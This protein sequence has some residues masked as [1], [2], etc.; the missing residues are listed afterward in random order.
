MKNKAVEA[1]ERL[2]LRIA[3]AATV[4]PQRLQ[5]AAVHPTLAAAAIMPPGGGRS[6]EAWALVPDD[7]K[8]MLKDLPDE[9]IDL[10]LSKLVQASTISYRELTEQ[11]VATIKVP[12]RGL[13]RCPSG[14]RDV[15]SD[16]C[17]A[18]LPQ[19][20][21]NTSGQYGFLPN[22][23]DFTWDELAE[24]RRAARALGACSTSV[25]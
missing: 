23:V 16:P 14:G 2:R 13:R 20:R 6:S 5:E 17:I 21:T 11:D 9:Q 7:I 12:H 18:L 24:G 8:E 15:G 19:E 4:Q 10:V 22:D 25:L 3:V 1:S